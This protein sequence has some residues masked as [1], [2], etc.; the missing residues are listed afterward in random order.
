[1]ASRSLLILPPSSLGGS[2]HLVLNSDHHSGYELG[3]FPSFLS[4]LSDTMS[5][6]TESGLVCTAEADVTWGICNEQKLIYLFWF[7]QTDFC[8]VIQAGLKLMDIL[9][10][11]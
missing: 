4:F 2:R 7:V 8:Y 5:R 3:M 6:L 10:L 9:C 1:M 11:P